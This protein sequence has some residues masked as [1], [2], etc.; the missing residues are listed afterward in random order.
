MNIPITK[1]LITHVYYRKIYWVKFLVLSL[2]GGYL[3]S[4]QMNLNEKVDNPLEEQY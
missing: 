1:K 2:A 3:I 4:N